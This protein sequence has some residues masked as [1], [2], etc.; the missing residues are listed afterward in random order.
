MS[1]INT[2]YEFELVFMTSVIDNL[3]FRNPTL[4]SKGSGSNQ[5]SSQRYNILNLM[6]E[7]LTVIA[8]KLLN[9]DPLQTEIYFLEYGL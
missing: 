1:N 2:L 4:T 6:V 8:N 9:L 5:R 7:T 3:P